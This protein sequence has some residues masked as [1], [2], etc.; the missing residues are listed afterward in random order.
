MLAN[1]IPYGPPPHVGLPFMPPLTPLPI[2]CG[3][4]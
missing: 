1:T 2:H 4:Q 3:Q